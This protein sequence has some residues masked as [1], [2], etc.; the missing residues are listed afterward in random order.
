MDKFFT[1][2]A[3]GS[4][5]TTI[6]IILVSLIILCL[7]LIFILA[8][9]QGRSISFWPP[10]IGEKP[11]DKNSLSSNDSQLDEKTKIQEENISKTCNEL[12]LI[13]IFPNRELFQNKYPLSTIVTEAT[14]GSKFRIIARTLFLLLNR[15]KDIQTAIMQGANVEMCFFD[16]KADLF[17]LRELAYFEIFDTHSAI[18]TF[19][20]FFV[21]WLKDKTPSG[22]IEIRY[23]QV[24]LLE[25]YFTFLYKGKQIA[26]WDLSF[27]RD[28]SAKRIMLF[29]T[30]IGLG[31]DL[32][33]RYQQIW[34]LS[35]AKFKYSDKTISLDELDDI[36]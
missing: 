7:L 13:E 15:P 27:G 18:S 29:D 36:Q 4:Q 28:I 35:K 34:E 33:G 3:S 5:T 17:I 6:F 25:S 24:H 12:G 2:L 10:K 9:L 8:F 11:S 30:K 22:S 16:T 26:I 1:W 21:D 23:H 20:R 14:T 32:D 19:K 31:A